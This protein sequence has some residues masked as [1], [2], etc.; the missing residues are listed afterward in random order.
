MT[1]DVVYMLRE[2]GPGDYEELRYSLRSLRNLPHGRVW[3]FGGSPPWVQGV[4]HV[5]VKQG[6]IKHTNTGFV[7]AT[8]GYYTER[9]SEEFY[10]FHDDYFIMEPIP[11]VRRMYRSTWAQWL[12][13]QSF[14]RAQQTQRVLKELG[15]RADLCYELHVPMVIDSHA[16]RDMI[17]AI[18]SRYDTGANMLCQVQKRSLYGN[19][20]GY[21]GERFPDPKIRIRDRDSMTFPSPYLSTSDTAFSNY[22][23]GMHLRQ[24]FGDPSPYEK[25]GSEVPTVL[26]GPRPGQRWYPQRPG[27]DAR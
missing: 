22:R 24:K 25:P 23:V 27:H 15:R 7:M 8:I 4:T 17:Q 5:E 9:L 1:R 6:K 18:E 21:G 26:Y 16:Y 2:G 3:I 14:Q 20:V 10:L 13:S 12:P 11:E 19:W